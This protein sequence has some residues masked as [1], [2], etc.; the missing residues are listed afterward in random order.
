[1]KRTE[2]CDSFVELQVCDKMKKLLQPP[3]IP[4]LDM[5][6]GMP[7]HSLLNRDLFD[8]G[9]EA[10]WLELVSKSLKGENLEQLETQLYGD[11]KIKPLYRKSK[12]TEPTTD[13]NLTSA[14]QSNRR[15]VSSYLPWDIRQTFSHTSPEVTNS[16]ILRDLE[17]GVSSVELK[18]ANKTVSGIHIHSLYDLEVALENVDASI[19]TVALDHQGYFGAN[20]SALLGSW[21]KNQNA[22]GKQKLT[23]NIDPTCIVSARKDKKVGYRLVADLVKKFSEQFPSLTILRSDARMIH[24]AGG[25]EVQELGALIAS[26]IETVRELGNFGIPYKVSAN[27]ILFTLSVSSNYGIETAKIRAARQ[28]WSQCLDILDLPDLQ[29]TIQGVTSNRMLT[30]YDPWT[31]IIRNT[32]ACFGAISGGC[33]SISVEPFTNALGVSSELGRRVARNTQIIA[34]EESNLGKVTDPASG[35]WFVEELTEKLAKKGW[36]EFQRIESEGGY[37]SSLRQ[38]HIQ[39]RVNTACIQQNISYS[40]SKKQTVGINVFPSIKQVQA[41]FSEQVAVPLTK[42]ISN[43]EVQSLFPETSMTDNVSTYSFGLTPSRS[44]EGFEYSRDIVE[45]FTLRTGVRPTIFIA[46][47]GHQAE[48]NLRLDFARK[49]FALAGLDTEVSPDGLSND[50]IVSCWKKTECEIVCLCGTDQS[51]QKH[52]QKLI[53]SIR[54]IHNVYAYLSGK[55]LCKEIDQNIHLGQNTLVV[56]EATVRRLGIVD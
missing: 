45:S 21:A 54:K 20:A 10:A 28:L 48:C 7:E 17:R 33:D 52:S 9:N 15:N 19:A 29:V 46:M 27:T 14:N 16:E 41:P 4:H 30:R 34:M 44:S 8:G 51:Y 31:N 37:L 3:C 25:S 12:E 32:C 56:L 42:G 47:L 2:F 11:L 13:H 50:E 1:M 26:A 49:F 22:S 24:E 43:E 36:E 40:E 53:H 6:K 18:L 5:E 38:G 55:Y 35:A 23:F 39:S